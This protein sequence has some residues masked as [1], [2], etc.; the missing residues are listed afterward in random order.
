MLLCPEVG[1]ATRLALTLLGMRT[2]LYPLLFARCVPLLLTDG[3]EKKKL[4]EHN[5]LCIPSKKYTH[6]HSC[7]QLSTLYLC[8]YTTLH[9]LEIYP[10]RFLNTLAPNKFIGPVL[11]SPRFPEYLGIGVLHPRPKRID[12][13]FGLICTDLRGPERMAGMG[14][15]YHGGAVGTGWNFCLWVNKDG[16]KG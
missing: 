16:A 3:P 4:Q 13:K 11:H 10:P 1:V 7:T 8:I 9:K 14:M 5:Y 2:V 6:S 15:G 12:R